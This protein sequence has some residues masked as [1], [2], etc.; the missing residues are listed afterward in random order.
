MFGQVKENDLNV[1][2]LG[3]WRDFL[4]QV[5]CVVFYVLVFYK[6]F[7]VNFDVLLN[8]V[9]DVVLGVGF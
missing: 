6:F 3:L 5:L 4:D 1:F 7:V 9:L 2:E 8:F